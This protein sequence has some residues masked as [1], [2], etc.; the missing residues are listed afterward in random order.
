[1]DKI[2]D[3]AA[4]IVAKYKEMTHETLDEMKLHKLLYFTQRESFAI[5]G[6]PAFEGDFEGWKYGPVSREVRQD[7]E[8]GEYLVET[9]KISDDMYYLNMEHWHH[10][11]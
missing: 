1:M 9:K 6:K 8:Q 11:N 2:I 5:L 3:V 7:Y 10:G 4:Y